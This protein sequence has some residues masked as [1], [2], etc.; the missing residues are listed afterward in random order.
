[1]KNL[2]EEMLPFWTWK[3]VKYRCDGKTVYDYVKSHL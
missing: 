1:M 3:R 2:A